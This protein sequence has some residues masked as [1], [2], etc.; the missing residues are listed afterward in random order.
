MMAPGFFTGFNHEVVDFPHH[1]GF[2]FCFDW[3]T[4]KRS[5]ELPL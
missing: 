2:F 3:S 5:V 4:F 1:P